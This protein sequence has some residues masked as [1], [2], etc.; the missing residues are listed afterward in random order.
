MIYANG[1]NSQEELML[2]PYNCSNWGPLI[3]HHDQ[4]NCASLRIVINCRIR[5]LLYSK[6]KIKKGEQLLYNYNSDVNEYPTEGFS[7]LK[8]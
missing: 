1:K 3:N 6:I 5:V 8:K 7:D 2:A 4:G